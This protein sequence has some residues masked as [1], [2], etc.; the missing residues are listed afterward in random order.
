MV[1]DVFLSLVF[2][3]QPPITDEYSWFYT[4]RFLN[5]ECVEKYYTACCRME[6]LDEFAV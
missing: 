1:G 5:P 3:V 4:C 2:K 6:D